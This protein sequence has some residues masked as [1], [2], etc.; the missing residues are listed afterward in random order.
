M[1]KNRRFLL[2]LLIVLLSF[3]MACALLD[4]FL[5]TQAPPPTEAPIVPTDEPNQSLPEPT[6]TEEP[7]PT[8]QPTEIPP[9]HGQILYISEGNVWRYL[10][11]EGTMTQLTFD[12]VTDSYDSTYINPLF[13]A[14]GRYASYMRNGVSYLH[15]LE[16]NSVVSLPAR[17][18]RWSQST[19]TA[20]YA[21]SGP[22]ECPAVD[23]LENQTEI[24]FD[25]RRYDV[26]ALESPVFIANITGGLFFPQTISEDEQYASIL[27]CACYSECGSHVL[28]HLPSNSIMVSP[29]DLYPGSIDFSPDS[30]RLVASPMQLY[31]YFE[32]SL[33][34]ANNDFTGAFPLYSAPNVAVVNPRWSPLGD[35]IAFTAYD[36]AGEMELDDKRAMIINLDGSVTL[37]IAA[38]NAE[39]NNWSP[40]ASQILFRRGDWE[41][42]T[43]FIYD[44]VSGTTT[45][46]PFTASWS[47]MDWGVL[48]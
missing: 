36:I 25:L 12:G 14:D 30:S 17:I 18:I 6:A 44:L 35:W 16:D 29:P 40:D 31:G 42:Y 5:P 45:E 7:T 9:N 1:K 21:A 41:A 8:T 10:V 3:T 39:F 22:F 33:Y 46:L 4:Q 28:H 11:D 20:F 38:G 48:P 47:E 23:N 19:P 32:S 27:H 37:E 2:P 43:P 24:N 26:A 13:S 15:N 34:M